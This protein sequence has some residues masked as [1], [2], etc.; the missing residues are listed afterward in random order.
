LVLAERKM[1]TDQR[2]YFTQQLQLVAEKVASLLDQLE[3]AEMVVV[4]EAEEV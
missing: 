2:Q 4:V 3:Q 1:Q